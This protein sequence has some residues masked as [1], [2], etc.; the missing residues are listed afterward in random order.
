MK[1]PYSYMRPF[2]VLYVSTYDHESGAWH[3]RQQHVRG[4][5]DINLNALVDCD[6]VTVKAGASTVKISGAG[7][8]TGVLVAAVLTAIGAL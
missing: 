2:A 6:A 3:Q 7:R 5:S 8:D 4:P 1:P